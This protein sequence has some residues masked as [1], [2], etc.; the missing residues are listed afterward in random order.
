M[1]FIRT[2]IFSPRN[3]GPT[4]SYENLFIN[5]APKQKGERKAGKNLIR[6]ERQNHKL[7][8]SKMSILPWKVSGHPFLLI[9]ACF[10]AISSHAQLKLAQYSYGKFGTDKFEKFEF[11]TQ[12][13]KHSEILY[14]YGKDSRKVRLKYEGRDKINGDSC[15]KVRFSNGSVLYI[16]PS[17][18]RLKVIDSF[19]KYSKIFSWEYE[20]PVNGRGTY[21]DVCAENDD[22]A[23]KILRSAYLR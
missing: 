2:L 9:L 23:I 17:D 19:G 21:C 3:L 18:L 12:G 10:L 4:I 15:F 20:G 5:V 13:G 14:S 1:I 7:T 6:Q 11:W 8:S 22:D 16:T